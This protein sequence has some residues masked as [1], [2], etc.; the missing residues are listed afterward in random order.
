MTAVFVVVSVYMGATW[1]RVKSGTRR[2]R[3]SY[4]AYL[5]TQRY[6]AMWERQKANPT[7]Y[8]VRFWLSVGWTAFSLVKAT[9]PN[10]R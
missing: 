5:T 3:K 7:Y 9:H 1:Y 6:R 8:S 4:L 2:P 10:L